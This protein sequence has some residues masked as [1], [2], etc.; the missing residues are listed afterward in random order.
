MMSITKNSDDYGEKCMK[1]KFYLDGKLPL[2]KTIESPS[3]IIVIRVIFHENKNY[4][5]QVF[6][7]KCLHEL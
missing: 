6:L 5:P 3:M 1:I 7:N 4:Y 2:N